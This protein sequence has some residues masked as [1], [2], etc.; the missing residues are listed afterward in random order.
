M[1]GKNVLCVMSVMSALQL[2]PMHCQAGDTSAVAQQA[3]WSEFAGRAG[4]SAQGEVFFTSKHGGQWS[5]ASCHG[6]PA[7][8]EGKHASTGKSIKPLAPSAN[9]EAFTDTSRIEKWFRRNCK[10]VLGREC[11]AP[12]KA[13][14]LA[15]LLDLKR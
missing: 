6:S 1:M 7:V 8:N 3:K 5:C 10:D 2:M 11:T 12:E 9:P 14:I 15:Y 13:D 4:N